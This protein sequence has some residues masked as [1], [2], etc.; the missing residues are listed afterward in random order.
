MALTFRGLPTIV[1]ATAVAGVAGYLV[2]WVVYR[3]IGPADYAVFAVFWAALY[4]VIG[5][6]SGIQ[7]EVT[8][9]TRRVEPGTRDTANPARNFAVVVALIVVVAIVATAPLWVTAVFGTV[10]WALVPPLALGAGSYVLVATLGGSL[11]GVAHWGSLAAMIT[12]DALLRL[13]LL[14]VGLLFTRDVVALAWIVAVP[15][16][17]SIMVLWPIIRRRFVGRTLLDVGYAGLTR[18]VAR[19]V[20]ASISAAALVSGFPLVLGIAGRDQSQALLGELIF[21][22]TLVRAPLVVTIMALQSYLLVMFRDRNGAWR[23]LFARIEALILVVG[24]VLAGAAWWVGPPVMAFVTGEPPVLSGS[25][26]ALLVVSS[27]LVGCLSVS[28][29]AVL[30]RSR[31]TAYTLGWVVAAVA[32]VVVVLLPIDFLTAVGTALIVGPLA[33]IATH[34][35]W[36]IAD[37]ARA[38]GDAEIQA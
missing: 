8:R 2:T 13:G 19:T 28:A 24:I 15:F 5:G 38:T 29:A 36:I 32:T 31:H 27:A 4:L 7:Q 34:V 22:I 16:P 37:R 17:L 1:L 14:L 3:Q 9:A 20:L 11:F 35:A 18:N 26:L 25:F 21:T 12:T 6:L 23:A 33:G 10:G 30:A